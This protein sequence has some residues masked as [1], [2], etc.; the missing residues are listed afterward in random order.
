M[1]N[2]N[3]AASPIHQPGEVIQHPQKI[4]SCGQIEI[5]FDSFGDPEDP[6]I[7]LIMGLATQLVHWHEDFCRQL[8]AQGFWVIRF[9]NRDIGQ[10]TILKHLPPPS[11]AKLAAN[12]YLKVSLQVPYTLDDMAQDALTLLDKLKIEAAHVVGVSMG[13]MIAQLMAIKHPQRVS[14]L[15]IIMSSNGDR[16]LMR[17]TVGVSLAILKPHPKSQAEH[18][19]QAIQMWRMLHGDHFTFPE[20]HFRETIKTAVKRGF[21]PSGV[22]RQMAAIAVA[23]KRSESLAKLKMPVLIVHGEADPLLKV[24]NAFALKQDIPHAELKIFPGMGHTLP[25]EIWD[26]LIEQIC[27]IAAHSSDII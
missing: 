25:F 20:Q 12:R 18:L 5:A 8:A 17:P 16:G 21:Y 4:I 11:L 14:S 9:D 26:E 27:N 2:T 15:T 19:E 24:K 6:A 10:S 23:P 1:D 22:L 13:G 3:T 7:L